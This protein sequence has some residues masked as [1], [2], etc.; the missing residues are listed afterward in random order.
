MKYH[1]FESPIDWSQYLIQKADKHEYEPSE[2]GKRVEALLEKLYLPQNSYSY[3]K[4]PQWFADS[5]D[6]GTEE[7]QV[8]YVMNHL[9]PNLYHFYK[10]PTQKDFRLGPDVVNLMVHQH[11]CE[12]TQATILNEDGSLFQD[13]VHDTHEE[14]LLLT[15]FFEHE[16]NDM[17]IRCARVSY[18]SSDAEIKACFLHAVHKRFG[19]MDPAAESFGSAT[20]LTKFT[21]LKQSTESLEY[22]SKECKTMKS[23]TIR[24]DYAAARISA[25]S[26]IIAAEAIGVTL[27]LILIQS[28]LKAV[29]PL[30]SESIL[31]LVLGSFVRTGTTAFCIFGVLSALAALY[32]SAC[33]TRERYFYIDKDELKFIA[34]TKEMFGWLKNS[35]PAIGCFAAAGAFII[36]AIS[37]I[38][39]IGIF[40]SGLSHETLGTLINVAVLMLHIAGGCIVASVACAVWDSNKI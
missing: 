26:A 28:L 2:P 6:K 36:M 39:D 34:K 19:L 8:R 14:I 30:T 11:M 22:I 13:G 37:L 16:F 23:D 4:F 12:N 27:L 25:I 40:D 9:C 15:L 1:G 38:A 32:V 33:A 35:K 3:A 24:N 29:T 7:E 5:S 31:M 18:T 21:S 10:N 20:S 17:D